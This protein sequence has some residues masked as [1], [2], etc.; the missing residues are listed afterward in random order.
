MINV[1]FQALTSNIGH[2]M[3]VTGAEKGLDDF[4]STPTLTFEQYR[5]YLQKEVFS[6][7]PDEVSI[8]ECSKIM[9]NK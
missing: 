8:G 7:L 3:G 5:F 9:F 2:V 1:V 6:D 4:Q